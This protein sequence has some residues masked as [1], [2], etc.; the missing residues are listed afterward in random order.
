MQAMYTTHI[1]HITHPQTHRPTDLEDGVEVGREGVNILKDEPQ[2]QLL[3]LH[4]AALVGTY[5]AQHVA[6][7][8]A[9]AKGLD[10]VGVELLEVLPGK[11]HARVLGLLPLERLGHVSEVD[12]DEELPLQRGAVRPAAREIDAQQHPKALLHHGDV[13]LGVQHPEERVADDER[14][15][16]RPPQQKPHEGRVVVGLV[17]KHLSGTRRVRGWGGV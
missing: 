1:T 12:V 11:G 17:L 16:Q 2:G 13:H 6:R 8:E 5:G 7:G 9:E 15:Q 10:E 14:R 3:A 4:H